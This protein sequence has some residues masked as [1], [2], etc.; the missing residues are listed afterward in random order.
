M[1]Y[2]IVSDSS[3]NYLISE[4]HVDYR[5]VPLKILIEGKEYSDADQHGQRHPEN[6]LRVAGIL[7]RQEMGD[8]P[9]NGDRQAG[10]GNGE[11]KIIG[12]KHRLKKAE[13]GI[14]KDPGQRDGIKN[15]DEFVDNSGDAQN[16]YSLG[17]RFCLLCHERDALQI[18]TCARRSG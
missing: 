9:G 1:K 13:P 3:S 2:R 10:A 8:K 4:G 17:D 6:P 14:P 11:E 18:N 12:R 15:A 16:R 5:T 7:P